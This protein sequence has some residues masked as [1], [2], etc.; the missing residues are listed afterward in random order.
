MSEYGTIYIP[1]D[2]E[3]SDKNYD[4]EE[5]NKKS[6]ETAQLTQIHPKKEIKSISMKLKMALGMSILSLIISILSIL[7]VLV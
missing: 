6:T 7:G 2:I 4:H 3:N 5:N 1:D